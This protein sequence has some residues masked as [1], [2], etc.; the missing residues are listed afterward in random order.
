[1]PLDGAE[2]TGELVA[3]ITSLSSVAAAAEAGRPSFEA[4]EA[5]TVLKRSLML[6]AGIVRAG[7]AAAAAADVAAPAGDR[8]KK[9]VSALWR[10]ACWLESFA[11]F[12]PFARLLGDAAGDAAGDDVRDTAALRFLLAAAEAPSVSMTSSSPPAAAAD[13]FAAAAPVPLCCVKCRSIDCSTLPV[14]ASM[15]SRARAAVTSGKMLRNCSTAA[16]GIEVA[17]AAADMASCEDWLSGTE[18]M[19]VSGE[20]S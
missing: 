8:L 2:G 4:D 13:D 15:S 5:A 6:A 20:L 17:A 9:E 14:H 10:L 1:M 3:A 12:L 11:S 7:E 16:D 18:M 19:T